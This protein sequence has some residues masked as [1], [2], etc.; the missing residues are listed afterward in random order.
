M[1]SILNAQ[2]FA[3]GPVSPPEV[4]PLPDSLADSWGRPLAPVLA[5]C[6]G[7]E[8]ERVI[9]CGGCYA[10]G[11][12]EYAA[13]ETCPDKILLGMAAAGRE[14]RARRL[15]VLLS[16]PALA[17]G[18]RQA[19]QRLDLDVEVLTLSHEPILAE[20]TAL[21]RAAAGA[22][23]MTAQ[24]PPWPSTENGLDGRPTVF[25]TP[26]SWCRTWAAAAGHPGWIHRHCLSL[27][28]PGQ[29]PRFLEGAPETTWREILEA[30]DL[31][32]P[33]ALLVGGPA[34]RV[35]GGGALEEPIAM[36]LAP[37]FTPLFDGN[38]IPLS[39][40]ACPVAALTRR[41]EA[42]HRAGCGRCTLC[43]V[44]TKQAA[45]V[46]RAVS[47]AQ[48]RPKE[49]E[50]LDELADGLR[51]GAGCS[52]GRGTGIGLADWMVLFRP[53]FEAHIRRKKCVP[54]VCPGCF[55]YHVLPAACRGCGVCA[56][57]CGEDA[58]MGGEG[59]IHVIDP[60]GCGKCGACARACPHG[61][62]VK[63]GPLKPR[64]PKAPIPVGTWKGR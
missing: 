20:P 22:A 55:T 8:G 63:A 52:F 62:I 15:A 4:R 34:G 46:A 41:M 23:P 49:L 7:R 12:G 44:G 64:G 58:V 33:R 54:L 21:F 9:V 5:D 43:R 53:E 17:G 51:E 39:G 30:W 24:P 36:A 29:A 19:A 32:P 56:Q 60:K 27:S 37:I 6:A 28:L 25:G 57:A 35:V 16:A 10:P 18:F 11:S 38:V 1:N 40:D 13:A 50:L 14:A 2:L 45:V 42:A 59:E 26:V 31:E 3:P 61:A 47:A 48:A